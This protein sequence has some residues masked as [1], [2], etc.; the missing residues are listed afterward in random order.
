MKRLI[1]LLPIPTLVG[2]K[3]SSGAYWRQV[4]RRSR[5]IARPACPARHVGFRTL[6]GEAPPTLSLAMAGSLQSK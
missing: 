4:A 1:T 3:E 5:K 2:L 6:P